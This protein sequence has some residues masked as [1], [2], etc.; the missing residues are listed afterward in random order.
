MLKQADL[1]N[2]SFLPLFT[3]LKM[4]TIPQ[5]IANHCRGV[6]FG[7]NWTDVNLKKIVSDV[8]WQVATAKLPDVNTIATLVYH[9]HYYISPIVKVLQGLPLVASDKYSFAVSAITSEEEWQQLLHNVFSDAEL[10][11]QQ[12][13]K[14]D[15]ALLFEIFSE[16][17]YGNYYQNLQG[18]IEHTHYHLGQIVIIKKLL[19]HIK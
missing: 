3:L 16:T 15:E 8:N 1:L 14:M 9:I 17:K 4:M 10:F 12:I 19:Q 18:I 2:V 5:Q 6:F 13:E 7:G 11:A